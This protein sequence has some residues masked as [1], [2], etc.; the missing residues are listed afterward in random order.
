MYLD[1]GEELLPGS[2]LDNY[3]SF[4]ALQVLASIST[5]A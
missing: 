4:E 2:S 3:A 1:T 5:A